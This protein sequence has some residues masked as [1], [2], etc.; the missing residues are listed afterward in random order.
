[1][2]PAKI[3]HILGQDT[4][5][6]VEAAVQQA[7]EAAD[8]HGG[9]QGAAAVRELLISMLAAV[10]ITPAE[11]APERA[12]EAAESLRNLVDTSIRIARPPH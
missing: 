3:E 8:H 10:I 7:C 2:P 6:A 11:G 1:M 9:P 12:A 4:V 5:A